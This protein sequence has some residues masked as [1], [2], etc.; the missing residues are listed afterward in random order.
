MPAAG[1]YRGLCGLDGAPARPAAA[2]AAAVPVAAPAAPLMAEL[3]LELP[4][5]WLEEP[6]PV[7][8]PLP[9]APQDPAHHRG[10]R[11]RAAGHRRTPEQP[12][13]PVEQI[14][15]GNPAPQTAPGHHAAPQAHAEQWPARAGKPQRPPQGARAEP[16]S[17]G[18]PGRCPAPAGR[19]P[20]IAGGKNAELD[21]FGWQASQRAQVLYDTALACRMRPFA[22]V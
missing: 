3:Q 21:E 19:V 13:R 6:A 8:E 2:A 10:R 11:A 17:P 4:L 12:A 9:E 1:R 16:R 22:D 15:G 7:A 18:S 14:P 5:A 20:A